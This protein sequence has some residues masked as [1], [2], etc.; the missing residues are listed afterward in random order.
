VE[1]AKQYFFGPLASSAEVMILGSGQIFVDIVVVGP[2][3]LILDFFYI[4]NKSTP[5]LCYIPSKSTE[6][7]EQKILFVPVTASSL[8]TT[9][10]S[11]T[12]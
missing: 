2:A 9:F 5:D 12:T 6:N 8:V 10:G 3:G 7:S 11:C 4:F 1:E